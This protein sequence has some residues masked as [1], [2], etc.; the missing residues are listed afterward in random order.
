[1][2]KVIN[3]L[4]RKFELVRSKK[5]D[6]L[7]SGHDK[8]PRVLIL[9]EHLN[10]TY[11]ISF[12]IPFKEL[13]RNGAIN[14]SVVSQ[15]K[16]S[17]KGVGV[18][19]EWDA[20]FRPQIV[21]F[22]R[23]GLPYGTEIL[24]YFRGKKVPVVYHIDDNLLDIPASL[25]EVIGKSHGASDV[26]EAR[27]YLLENCDLIYA[28]TQ[29]LAQHLQ[30][31]FPQQKIFSGMYA[32]YMVEHIRTERKPGNDQPII[33]Y[34]G[35]RGHQEDLDLVVPSLV[36]LLD[37]NA[38]IRFEVFGSIKMPDELLRFG[39]RV[40]AHEV[41]KDYVGFLNKLN[42]LGWDVGLAPLVDEKFN[43][44]KAPTKFVEYTAAGIPVIA[45]DI[46]V[47][48]PFAM[49]GCAVLVQDEWYDAID[50]LLK[51]SG[52][53]ASMV[54]NAHE[55]CVSNFSEKRLQDQLVTLINGLI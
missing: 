37:D 17:R 5:F 43:L 30:G 12:D 7:S 38:S 39:E 51:D 8:S 53:R 31:L 11:Y 28:S 49:P 52:L 44:C 9:T 27:R 18:W 47:Y 26:I 15:S 23:Y 20:A 33:G 41:C 14:Y 2:L 6:R 46:Q 25:G 48:S 29:Y 10:A 50:A 4:A 36:R 32:P 54:K 1:M 42:T 34:M 21:I 45:S 55:Y 35:S 22:T 16:I 24:E 13:S 40:K 19:K 3:Y